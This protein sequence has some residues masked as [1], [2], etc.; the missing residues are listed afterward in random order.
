M[1]PCS[2]I[3]GIPEFSV[4]IPHFNQPQWLEKTLE[5]IFMQSADPNGDI[6]SCEV[7]VVDNGSDVFPSDICAPY[8]G[9][10]L[11]LETEKGPGPA[12]NS[13]AAAARAPVI[14]FTDSDCVVASDWLVTAA[15]LLKEHPATGIF[16]GDVS[17]L[18][19]DPDERTAIECYEELYAYR[20]ELMVRRYKFAPT[21]NIIVRRT[22]FEAVGPFIPGLV[23]SEDVEW[24]RRAHDLGHPI[25]F[26][27]ELR[28][29]TPARDSFAEVARR[30]DR[31]VGQQHAEMLMLPRGK[32][33]WAIKT[34]AM[35]FSPL[36]EIPEIV[37]SERLSHPKERLKAF[38]CLVQTRLWRFK[39]MIQLMTGHID[40]AWLAG[41]W[42]RTPGT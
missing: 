7:I 5:S 37:T 16:C 39:R 20:P 26:T 30:W 38:S 17:I 13:G 6:P 19:S 34:F 2:H 27:P 41:A 25:L 28:I 32:L 21:C 12:R 29:Q 31:Q 40:N 15:R 8:P 4:V 35:P 36:A 33:R 3:G 23:L 11:L 24:G 42:R 1:G 14:L 10:R 22:I 18:P 9:V